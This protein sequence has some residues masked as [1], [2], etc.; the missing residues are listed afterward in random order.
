V[1][2]STPVKESISD[3]ISGDALTRSLDLNSLSK[4]HD[5]FTSCRGMRMLQ[6]R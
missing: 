5:T 4:S 1:H 3:S 2:L 6:P